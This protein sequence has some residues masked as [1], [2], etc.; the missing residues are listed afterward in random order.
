MKKAS[1]VKGIILLLALGSIYYCDNRYREEIKKLKTELNKPVPKEIVRVPSESKV[2]VLYRGIYKKHLESLIESVLI[3]LGVQHREDWKKLLLV[4][5]MT[6]SDGGRYLK[7]IKG[8]A[9]GVMMLEL[10]T[11]KDCLAWCKAKK[12]ELYRKIK[13]LRVPAKLKSH[14]AEYN[15]AY[16]IAMAYMEY[17]HRKVDPRGKDLK[18][19][20]ELH[21]RYYNTYLGKSTIKG[22]MNKSVDITSPWLLTEN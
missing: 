14:E 20:A 13:E 3:H 7:Q 2:R 16:S 1:L 17:V 6:E 15:L 22:T 9:K 12:P 11:E 8:P 5:I 21:K 19:L 10:P 18:G 4:T